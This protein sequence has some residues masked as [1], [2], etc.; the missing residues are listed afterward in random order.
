[1]RG[2]DLTPNIQEGEGKDLRF[3]I[4]MKRAYK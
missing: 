4:R 2:R 3:I 1:M